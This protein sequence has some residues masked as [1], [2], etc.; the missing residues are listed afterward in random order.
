MINSVK[1]IEKNFDWCIPEYRKTNRII[2]AYES[3]KHYW[4][5]YMNKNDV[6]TV[7]VQS[8]NNSV[9]LPVKEWRSNNNNY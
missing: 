9:A 6:K 2:F 1:V 3:L 4:R 5:T 8:R 7:W